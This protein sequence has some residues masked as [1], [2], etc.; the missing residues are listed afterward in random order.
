MY[1]MINP[2]LL[3]LEKM[4]VLIPHFTPT[5]SGLQVHSMEEAPK[6]AEHDQLMR[7]TMRYIHNLDFLRRF[8][9]CQKERKNNTVQYRGNR[10][11]TIFQIEL[12]KRKNPTAA[13]LCALYL[14]TAD[15]RVWRRVRMYI[16]GTGIQFQGVRLGELSP[17]AYTLYMTAKDLYC[18]TKHITIRDLADKDVVSAQLFELVCEAMTIRRYGLAACDTGI[19]AEDSQ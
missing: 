18:G 14:L 6:N 1:F 16:H 5:T 10:H 9:E 12:Q 3:Q 15:C 7:E 19:K 17:D 4:M 2:D 13:M 8:D 11:R